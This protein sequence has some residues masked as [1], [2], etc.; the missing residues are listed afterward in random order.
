MIYDKD[1]EQYKAWLASLKPGDQAAVGLHSRYGHPPSI[2]TLKR[3]TATQFVM[4][5]EFDREERYR[6]DNGGKVGGSSF[7]G[8]RPLTDQVRA[9]IELHGHRRWLNDI[10]WRDDKI[11][12]IPAPVIAA[13]RA[14]YDKGMAEHSADQE[15][16]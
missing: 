14:A 6:R 13:M 7:D 11:K 12:A 10:S 5:N 16:N 8:I 3:M 4:A 9:A 1:R 2:L 15:E